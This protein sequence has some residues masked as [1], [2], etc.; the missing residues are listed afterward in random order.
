MSAPRKNACSYLK[1][2][3]TICGASCF[4]HVCAVHIK[5]ATQTPCLLC[6]KGTQ[7]ATGY[8]GAVGPC[9]SA[10]HTV[11]SRTSNAKYRATKKAAAVQK[12][13]ANLDAALDE[14]LEDF[15]SAI[16]V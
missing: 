10:Q 2:D 12:Q 8:C 7:S 15:D 14:L 5:C 16:A 4:R 13:S 1:S 9:R 11:N 6:G 3:G